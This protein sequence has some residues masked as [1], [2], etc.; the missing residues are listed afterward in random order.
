MSGEKIKV[1]F[2][3]PL[4]FGGPDSLPGLV[5]R[6]DEQDEYIEQL[7]AQVIQLATLQVSTSNQIAALAGSVALLQ[8]ACCA[9]VVILAALTFEV[10]L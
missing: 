7:G 9:L 6:V 1:Q 2:G 8:G 4:E 10:V 3:T 5:V